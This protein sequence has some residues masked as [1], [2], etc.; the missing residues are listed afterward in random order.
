[1]NRAQLKDYLKWICIPILLVGIYYMYGISDERVITNQVHLIN[2]MKEGIDQ[3]KKSTD[4]YVVKFEKYCE[5]KAIDDS[6][7]SSL[8]A[9]QKDHMHQLRHYLGLNID[10]KVPDVKAATTIV[11][12]V[13][14]QLIVILSSQLTMLEN[15]LYDMNIEEMKKLQKAI[16]KE[17][18]SLF[19]EVQ[20][21]SIKSQIMSKSTELQARGGLVH[22]IFSVFYDF[23]V[24]VLSKIVMPL[25]VEVIYKVLHEMIK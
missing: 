17:Q 4:Q 16:N 7:F 11:R 8:S 1:M 18:I 19:S 25:T 24:M 9:Q 5:L 10:I 2:A 14:K 13:S 12:E 6:W 22:Q 21:E 20:M 23:L 3:A 15:A